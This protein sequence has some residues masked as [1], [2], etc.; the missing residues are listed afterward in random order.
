MSP[1]K[2]RGWL[3]KGG[4]G[5]KLGGSLHGRLSLER[6]SLVVGR[7]I[8]YGLREQILVYDLFKAEQ[9][10]VKPISTTRPRRDHDVLEVMWLPHDS[11]IFFV[12]TEDTRIDSG[13]IEVW[14]TN[15]MSCESSYSTGTVHSIAMS[16]CAT[17]HDLV[18]HERGWTT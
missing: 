14:D 6:L 17:K 12:G 2:E 3:K 13:R 18:S 11:G 9:D 4:K 16:P 7:Y 5:D 8:L 15:E 1:E 10:N